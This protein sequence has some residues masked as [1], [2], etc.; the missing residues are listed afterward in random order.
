MAAVDYLHKMHF[1]SSRDSKANLGKKKKRKAKLGG[2]AKLEWVKKNT[3]SEEIKV[4]SYRISFEKFSYK[5]MR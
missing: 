1:V 5:H 3:G 2:K 4:N